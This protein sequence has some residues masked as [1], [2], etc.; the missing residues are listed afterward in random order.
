V[1]DLLEENPSKTRTG[2]RR[3]AILRALAMRKVACAAVAALYHTGATL[4]GG[5]GGLSGR[6]PRFEGN[7]C[8]LVVLQDR[9]GKWGGRG[10]CQR[11]KGIERKSGC[12]HQVP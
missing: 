10:R 12:N 6:G 9:T 2:C 4:Q 7:A 3:G 1:S 5:G 8:S 11:P